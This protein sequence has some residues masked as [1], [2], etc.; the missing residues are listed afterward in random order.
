VFLTAIALFYKLAIK[1]DDPT[2]LA[3][4]GIGLIKKTVPLAEIVRCEPTRIRWWYGWGIHLTP[5]EWLYNISGL[6]AVAIFLRNG[7]RFALGT[8]GPQE[9]VAAIRHF[10]SAE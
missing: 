7:Q 6:D 10:N 9:L 3:S 2:L 1:I 4:F 8:D 5:Y